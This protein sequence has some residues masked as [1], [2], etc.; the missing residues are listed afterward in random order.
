MHK[1]LK[2]KTKRKTGKKTIGRK[3]E[4]TQNF[5]KGKT[6]TSNCVRYIVKDRKERLDSKFDEGR[7]LKFLGFSLSLIDFLIDDC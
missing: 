3:T 4:G 5:E 1:Y 7:E 6:R 2:Q